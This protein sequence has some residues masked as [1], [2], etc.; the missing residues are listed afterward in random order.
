MSSNQCSMPPSLASRRLPTH[1]ERLLGGGPAVAEGEVDLEGDGQ[2]GAGD[3]HGGAHQVGHGVV[4]GR[5]HL[6]DDLV[7]DLEDEPAAVA[8]V[9]QRPIESDESDLED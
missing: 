4:L 8:A 3:G 1:L 9:L 5:W 7:V 2:L 6:E